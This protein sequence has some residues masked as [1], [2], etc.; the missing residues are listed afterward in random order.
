V[1]TKNKKTLYLRC[2]R[3]R[4]GYGA[5]FWPRIEQL[6]INGDE[7]KTATGLRSMGKIQ[8]NIDWILGSAGHAEPARTH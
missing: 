7:K 3:D 6:S 1:R 5:C 4:R 8:S 2:N